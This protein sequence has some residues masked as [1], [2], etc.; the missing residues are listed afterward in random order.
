MA[1]QRVPFTVELKTFFNVDGTDV[2]NVFYAD[3][4][5]AYT[6]GEVFN[7]CATVDSVVSGFAADMPTQDQYLRTDARG[8]DVENDVT[9]TSNANAQSGSVINTR[10]MPLNVAFC[11]TQRSNVTGRSAR[12][13]CYVAGIP[14]TYMD[15]TLDSQ[16][17]VT[18]AAAAAFTGHVDAV[19]LGIDG[20]GI[21]N[22]VIV[23]RYNAGSKRAVGVTFPWVSSDYRTLLVATRRSRLR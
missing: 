15:S 5:I 4:G 11:V 22:A 21:W 16:S 2:S 10:T 3:R 17:H 14:S 20:L 12:G 1:Y 8:L 18:A 6:L 19:R 9:A 23:S 13:R 7:L